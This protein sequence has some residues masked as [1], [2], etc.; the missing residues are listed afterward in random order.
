VRKK[1]FFEDMKSRDVVVVVVVLRVIFFSAASM[2]KVEKSS[3]EILT[4]ENMQTHNVE[5]QFNGK[6]TNNSRM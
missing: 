3:G 2:T 6:S 5:D 4:D 1:T